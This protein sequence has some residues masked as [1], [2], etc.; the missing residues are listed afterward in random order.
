[1]PAPRTLLVASTVA[2]TVLVPAAA[3]GAHPFTD[4][5]D[6]RFFS[7]A[8]D[9]AY[10]NG[11]TTGT[12]ATTFSG[13]DPV[14][15]NQNITFTYRYDQ[16]I[17][18]PELEDLEAR[19]AD[20]EDRTSVG[21]PLV[22]HEAAPIPLNSWDGSTVTLDRS[23]TVGVTGTLILDY[24]VHL[25]VADTETAVADRTVNAAILLDGELIGRTST[26]LDFDSTDR[27][28]NGRTIIAREILQVGPGNY[29]L[30]GELT[31]NLVGN[32]DVDVS[33][34][35]VTATFLPRPFA[36]NII[37]AE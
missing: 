9:W 2:A 33:S 16:E 17:I 23:V 10:N 28:Q 11:I 20:L 6:G 31:A 27:S 4:V 29:L 7:D 26:L 21:L 8:V 32:A 14:T 13:E 1:M 3:F 36:T 19:I 30:Q 12:S 22:Y 15:R 24:V 35:F 5:E 34:Q 37:V 25:N 18:R